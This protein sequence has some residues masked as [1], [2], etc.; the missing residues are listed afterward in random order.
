MFLTN[1]KHF[2]IEFSNQTRYVRPMPPPKQFTG[3]ANFAV[4]GEHAE[5][6]EAIAE[7]NHAAV[8]A[9]YRMLFE[10]GLKAYRRAEAAKR[11]EQDG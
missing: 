2:L 1:V 10:R 11:Q 8:G 3:M 4:K 7:Q 5:F 6:V 9:I